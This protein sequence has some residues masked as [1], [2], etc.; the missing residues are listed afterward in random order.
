MAV[1]GIYELLAFSVPVITATKSRLIAALK[2]IEFF[3]WQL[4]LSSEV[5]APAS[6]ENASP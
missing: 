4:G 3:D 1:A 5:I 6:P 2:F